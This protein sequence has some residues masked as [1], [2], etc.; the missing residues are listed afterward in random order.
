MYYSEIITNILIQKSILNK[1]EEVII[2]EAEKIILRIKK[3]CLQMEKE[4]SSNSILDI[5]IIR[6]DLTLLKKRDI[7][8][9][10]KTRNLQ[11]NLIAIKYLLVVYKEEFIRN[12]AKAKS[13]E[14]ILAMLAL[15]KRK[16]TYMLS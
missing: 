12:L 16:R 9:T 7:E 2:N 3:V 4:G 1:E 5:L 14:D 13:E 11:D 6:T 8:H 10:L 15:T